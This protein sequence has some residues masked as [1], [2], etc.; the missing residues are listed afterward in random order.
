MEKSFFKILAQD[1]LDLEINTIIK[2]D[3]SAVKMPAQRRQALYELSKIYHLKLQELNVRDPICWQYAGLRSFGEL[4]DRAKRGI[5]QLNN[6]LASAPQ[7]D[8]S[9]IQ[10]IQEDIKMLER[11]QDQS[12]NI[13]DMFYTLRERVKE[14]MQTN[15]QGYRDVPSHIPLQ[16]LEDKQKRG[17][18]QPAA[19]HTDSEMWNN[20][21]TRS[22]MNQLDDLDLTPQQVTLLRKAWEIG[23]E[24]IILLTVIQIDGDVTTRLSEGFAKNPNPMLLQIHNDSIATAMRFWSNLVQ[25]LANIAGKAFE[26]IV[27]G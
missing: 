1:L 26:A 10:K 7:E 12:I 14:Q 9:K 2:Q 24:K 18:L 19:P 4:R 15:Q 3:M 5:E 20:D 17:E 23:T 8:Q 22:R 13:V 27:S 21:I 16:E 6:K 11:I 25:T